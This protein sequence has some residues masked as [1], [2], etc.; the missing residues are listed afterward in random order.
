[1]GAQLRGADR[2]DSVLQTIYV[3]NKF[4]SWSLHIFSFIFVGVWTKGPNQL[5]NNV[6]CRESRWCTS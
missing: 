5:V 6:A 2:E 4:L 3:S 1:M